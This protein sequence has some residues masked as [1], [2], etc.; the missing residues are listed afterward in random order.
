[1]YSNP[2]RKSALTQSATPYQLSATPIIQLVQ[3]NISQ[4]AYLLF[5]PVYDDSLGLHI[6]GYATGVFLV[7]Q[8]LNAGLPQSALNIF[9]FEVSENGGHE[10]FASSTH[11]QHP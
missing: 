10:I 1:M 3:S 2:I 11:A 4:P 9:D 7:S 8:T 6:R 5:A